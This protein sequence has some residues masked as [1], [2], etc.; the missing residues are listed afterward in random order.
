VGLTGNYVEV[1]FAGPASLMRTLARVRVTGVHGDRV[2][3]ELEA[4]GVDGR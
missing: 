1:V 2:L 4:G 3:G